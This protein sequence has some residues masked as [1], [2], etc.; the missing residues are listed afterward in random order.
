MFS[1]KT[2]LCLR[3]C[4]L[5]LNRKKVLLKPDESMLRNFFERAGLFEEMRRTGHDYKTFRAGEKSVG[6]P[7]HLDDR[8]V[9]S[10]DNQQSRRGDRRQIGFG[11]IWSAAP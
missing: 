11:Q 7:I 5:V 1:S 4:T 6:R 10:T 9:V 3:T 2:L 8:L